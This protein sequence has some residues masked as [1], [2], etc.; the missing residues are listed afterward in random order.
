MKKGKLLLTLGF[1]VF[2]VTSIVLFAD[3]AEAAD[4]HRLYNP[5]S[6]EHFYTAN[7]NEKIT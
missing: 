4:M 3:A 6:G 2:A 5:N 7:T 1:S